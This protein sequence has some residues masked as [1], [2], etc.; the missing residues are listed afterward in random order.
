MTAASRIFRVAMD[1]WIAFF[2]LVTAAWATLFFGAASLAGHGKP[3]DLGPGMA[4]IAPLLDA[5]G[6]HIPP[7]AAHLHSS[8]A[9]IVA[10]WTLM[11]LS[12]MTPTAVPMLR[13]YRHMVEGGAGCMPQSNFF[14]LIT[15]YASV[16][17]LFSVIAGIAQY[18]LAST[19]IVTIAGVSAAPW[20]SASL[21]AL[22]G[23][24]QFSTLKQACLSRCRSPMAFFLSHWR[25]G[26]VGALA[27]GLRHGAVCVGCCWALM[28]LAF[29][30]GSM[31]LA[32]MGGAMILMIVEK[33]PVGR[34]LT[35]PLGI[36]LLIA[37]AMIAAR[38]LPPL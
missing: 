10:M 9:V 12:M 24:Y 17:V 21:L 2:A 18:A 6:G 27:M 20:L 33:L 36:V 32:W 11:S 31:N 23:A 35:A 15:G 25:E 22:A 16:W 14:A 34:S 1:P 7:H 30:G 4:S 37:A 26:F 19:D 28:A 5:I 13:T 38:A 3:A 8:L 29:V